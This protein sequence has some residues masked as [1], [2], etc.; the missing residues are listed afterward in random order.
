M[1]K[2]HTLPKTSL[3]CAAIGLAIASNAM[4]GG[5]AATQ[6]PSVQPQSA[7]SIDFANAIPMP[8]PKNPNSSSGFAPQVAPQFTGVPGFS[9]GGS[10]DGE[11][12]PTFVPKSNF[13]EEDNSISSQDFGATNHPFSTAQVNAFGN[14]T[15]KYFPYSPT[16]KL[17]FN[18]GDLS[19][20]CSASL[21]KPGVIV[22]AAH[23]VAD[24]G[25]NFYSNW[26]FVPA[27]NGT[28]APY[29][30]W[31]TQD[32]WVMTSYLDGSEAC[33]V[34]GVVCP[35][36]VAVIRLAPK[37][38]R[39][40][41]YYAGNKTGWYGYGWNGYG[42]TSGFGQTVSQVSQLGYPQAIDSGTIMQR[43][44]SMGYVDAGSSNNLVI[45]SLMTGG[46]SG[47]PWLVNLGMAPSLSGISFGS[48]PAYNVVTN[49]TSW[50]YTDQVWK[51]MGASTFTD[52]NI[53]TLVNAVCSSATSPGC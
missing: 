2:L 3:L 11:K 47:G 21:I 46:S 37:R 20:V 15:S 40:G 29:G 44:D 30:S 28:K 18:K 14:Q 32:A 4:A 13:I 9:A 34:T 51:Q 45:G 17:Y 48:A 35:N 8:L 1:K 33:A 36:D 24:F 6:S 39:T 25:G 16:G 5:S 7:A 23:C 27:L 38:T 52:G 53:I 49:V 19:Y 42:Y 10:G 12:S 43:N 41:S 31:K 22:T 50:G 26:T